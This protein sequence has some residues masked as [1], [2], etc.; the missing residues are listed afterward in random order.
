MRPGG[1][2]TGSRYE[3]HQRLGRLHHF[4]TKPSKFRLRPAIRAPFLRGTLFFEKS[5][6]DRLW[7]YPPPE[8]STVIAAITHRPDIANLG[9]YVV[10]GLIFAGVA[11]L[12]TWHLPGHTPQLEPPGDLTASQGE[13]TDYVELSWSAVETA[14]EYRIYRD[15]EPFATVDATDFRDN[16]AD[17]G[18]PPNAPEL[19]ASDDRSDGVKLQWTEPTV[20]AGTTHA[21]QVHAIDVDADLQSERSA[22]AT[23][24]RAAQPVVDYELKI[25]RGDWTS[26]GRETSYFDDGADEILLHRVNKSASHG[27]HDDYVKLEFEHSVP[28][29]G[30]TSEY[31]IR[32]VN[33]A[34]SGTPS[35]RTP[36]RR[37]APESISEAISYQWQRSADIDDTDFEDIPGA[38]TPQ[39]HDTDVDP[40]ATHY[41]RLVVDAEVMEPSA[42]DA[43]TGFRAPPS[44]PFDELLDRCGAPV[45]ATLQLNP[46]DIRGLEDDD[47]AVVNWPSAYGR[48]LFSSRISR[49]DDADYWSV[50]TIGAYNIRCLLLVEVTDDTLRLLDLHT[51]GAESTVNEWAHTGYFAFV[52]TED[53][54]GPYFGDAID[55]IAIAHEHDDFWI[56]EYSGH[57][58]SVDIGLG[59]DVSYTGTK[60]ELFAYHR[61]VDAPPVVTDT[62][63]QGCPWRYRDVP[64]DVFPAP[65][66]QAKRT[67]DHTSSYFEAKGYLFPC[68]TIDTDVDVDYRSDAD[69]VHFVQT[70]RFGGLNAD[71]SCKSIIDAGDYYTLEQ[72][73][74]WDLDANTIAEQCERR[75]LVGPDGDEIPQHDEPTPVDIS[76]PLSPNSYHTAYP[77]Q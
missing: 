13:S 40:G 25:R 11:S 4:C 26:V 47:D 36:G 7:P 24:H 64:P 76:D 60:T 9:M 57:Y 8:R 14:S 71:S 41:Y 35:D 48:A 45:E 2:V 31:R 58:Y 21:Y 28:R 46:A 1:L 19:T 16:D 77:S 54:Y 23:G 56:I 63:D 49:T 68:S 32:A 39:F 65:Y 43:I 61:G 33:A 18:G 51:I 3:L 22:P 53:E 59:Y 55:E 17:V 29:Y 67:I 5:E 66:T 37:K 70:H 50:V 72:R 34:G 75:R 6:H 20:P 52:A 30:P 62:D 42:T 74:V 69:E 10:T 15:G 27:E 73:H 44:G 12:V 38:D